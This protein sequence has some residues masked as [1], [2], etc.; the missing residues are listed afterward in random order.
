MSSIYCNYILGARILLD[1]ISWRVCEFHL[2][3]VKCLVSVYS[4][5]FPPKSRFDFIRSKMV[6]LGWSLCYN[7]YFWISWSF[8]ADCFEGIA[9]G[10]VGEGIENEGK[11]ENIGFESGWKLVHKCPLNVRKNKEPVKKWNRE[12]V[13]THHSLWSTLVP[14]FEFP[15]LQILMQLII[16]II[17]EDILSVRSILD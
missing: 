8:F 15:I 9:V 16:Q 17:D 2:N 3:L 7:K 1:C 13:L 6:P 14:K 4:S 11:L 12:R 10:A 5:T